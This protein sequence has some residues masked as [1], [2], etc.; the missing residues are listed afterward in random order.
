M[1]TDLSV[2]LRAEDEASR[3]LIAAQERQKELI[4]DANRL[5]EL[6]LAALEAPQE[7]PVKIKAQAPN[8]TFLRSIAAKNKERAVKRIL[9]LFDAAT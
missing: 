5:R 9:E 2:I 6:R 1:S 8:L 4:A 3:I 7:R